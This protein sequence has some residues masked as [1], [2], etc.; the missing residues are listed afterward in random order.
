MER[1]ELLLLT[2]SVYNTIYAKKSIVFGLDKKKKGRKK[3]MDPLHSTCIH[4]VRE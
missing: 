1:N 3:N 2:Y 4:L